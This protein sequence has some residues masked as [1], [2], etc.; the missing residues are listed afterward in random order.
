MLSILGYDGTTIALLEPAIIAGWLNQ[1]GAKIWLD[2]QAPTTEEMAWLQTVFSLPRLTG[3]GWPV[4]A[5]ALHPTPRWITGHL[6]IYP[7]THLDFYLGQ[8]VLLTTHPDPLPHLSQ[9]WLTYQQDMTRWPYGL[10]YLLYQLLHHLTTLSPAIRQ[11]IQATRFTLT[12]DQPDTPLL[13]LAHQLHSQK[14][15]QQQAQWL[16]AQLAQPPHDLMDATTRHHCQQLHQQIT[17]QIE[18]INLWQN[19]LAVHQQ[20]YQTH[21]NRQTQKQL[22]YLLWVIILSFLIGLL[23]IILFTIYT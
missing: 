23:T 15:H 2:V 19:W 3:E 20:Q 12:E 5:A 9:L 17:A 13:H 22:R 7:T 14:Y 18:E 6:P 8:S 4:A 1:A 21:Q 10:D 11:T 16:M